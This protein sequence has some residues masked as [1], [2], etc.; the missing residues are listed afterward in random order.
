MAT[1]KVINDLIDLNQTGNT[2]G[3]KGCVGTTAQQPNNYISVDFL[4]VGAGGGTYGYD[5][6][7]GGGG[8][9]VRTSFGSNSGGGSSAETSAS[10]SP[11]RNYI[12]TVGE[13]VIKSNGE[14]SIFGNI[15]SIGG[16]YGGAYDGS[17][18]IKTGG[19]GGSGGGGTGGGSF[20]AGA[21]TT[22]QGFAGGAGS[23]TVSAYPGGGG[24]G[25]GGA[26]QAAPNGNTLGN[27][28]IGTI[29][30]ILPHGTASTINVGE[31]SGTDV[32]YGGGAG[33]NSTI[34][35][36]GG[37]G[38]GGL[39]GGADAPN[40]A[41]VVNGTV[42]TGGGGA[43]AIYA[44]STYA[45]GGS[46][47]VIL[48]YSSSYTLSKT[49][50]L[51]EAAG[52]PFTEGSDYISVF[53]SGTGTVS[54]SGSF[55]SDIS[56]EG[57]L[58][59]NT[60][61]TSGNSNSAMQFYKNPGD[62]TNTGW[63]TLT[64]ND[65]VPDPVT[66]SLEVYLSVFDSTS[67]ANFTSGTNA[68]NT[69]WVDISSSGTSRDGYFDVFSGTN[70]FNWDAANKII[71][72]NS[73]TKLY[74]SMPSGYGSTF[75]S[76]LWF[77]IPASA[78]SAY[79]QTDSQYYSAGFANYIQAP[80]GYD[81]QFASYTGGPDYYNPSIDVTTGVWHQIVMSYDSNSRYGWIDG[82]LVASDIRGSGKTAAGANAQ[83]NWGWFSWGTSTTF[84]GDLGIIRV[85]TDKLTDAEV[86]Q[87]WNANKGD[88]G[89]S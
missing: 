66:S 87:N 15:N 4:V 79:V 26:G 42:N 49:G 62:L 34:S 45:K 48:R 60:D 53:T 52:S 81:M 40:N 64:N 61:L 70:A 76:E 13:G 56:D 21:G 32:Y 12:V 84:I 85:Y 78:T 41:S 46:G 28:G 1:T 30:N 31:V 43:G 50:T 5:S 74:H 68:A 75:T 71:T 77:K 59:T 67:T 8:G 51:V 14:T 10:I 33:G 24:G 39:G 2:E 6:P 83:I 17:S 19:D 25:S 63:F 18:S 3:L 65:I 86:L 20:A 35:A 11:G 29:V 16:G 58:R 38:T 55:L 88:F 72:T 44:S 89:L 54:F 22:N 69:T 37:G 7:G 9:G 80:G 47:V 36:S 73:K 27:G 23:P 57:A 82:A